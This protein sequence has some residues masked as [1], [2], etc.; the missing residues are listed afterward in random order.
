MGNRYHFEIILYHSSETTS[1]E[2]G[3][4][5]REMDRICVQEKDLIDRMGFEEEKIDIFKLGQYG[6]W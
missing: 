1:S 3:I 2:A 6:R 5:L 4:V